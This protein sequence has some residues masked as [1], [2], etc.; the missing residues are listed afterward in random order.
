MRP[1]DTIREDIDVG[2]GETAP[3]N[4]DLLGMWSGRTEN[5]R[6]R[7]TYAISDGD[8]PF[9][10]KLN[11][12]CGSDIRPTWE[13]WTN[14]D[15]YPMH[16]L[17]L[18][19]DVEKGYLPFE[20]NYFDHVLSI[21]YFEHIPHRSVHVD[22]ELM[23]AIIADL[24]RVSKNGAT[25]LIITPARPESLNG[26]G[27]CRLVTEGTWDAWTVEA[28]SAERIMAMEVGK[29]DLE[30]VINQRSWELNKFFGRA[31]SKCMFLRVKK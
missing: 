1:G 25:W 31:F 15:K 30:R 3:V 27:H 28:S 9:G 22:G 11:L 23:F 18:G 14:V 17:V 13:G 19:W 4:E 5:D 8:I 16:A 7:K 29:L 12:G 6:K 24:I 26:A 2:E 10:N 21:D 20:D